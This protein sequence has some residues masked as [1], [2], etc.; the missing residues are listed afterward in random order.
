[1]QFTEKTKHFG[2]KSLDS[3]IWETQA[4]V[5]GIVCEDVM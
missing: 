3:S 2:R 4:Q 1:M 5:E